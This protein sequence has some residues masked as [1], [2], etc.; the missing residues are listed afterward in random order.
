M[1]KILDFLGPCRRTRVLKISI[2]GPSTHS[3]S[4]IPFAGGE[5]VWH[6]SREPQTQL[7]QEDHE[8]ERASIPGYQDVPHGHWHHLASLPKNPHQVGC[9]KN[10][11]YQQINL[12]LL[13]VQRMHFLIQ[14]KDVAFRDVVSSRCMSFCRVMMLYV[15]KDIQAVGVFNCP[16]L[17]MITVHGIL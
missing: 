12:L 11:G 14:I 7:H 13:C 3:V 17:S 2:M 1:N 10:G 5:A 9:S 8:P 6:I 16:W 15:A 4:D